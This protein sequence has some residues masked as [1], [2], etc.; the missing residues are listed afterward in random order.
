MHFLLPLSRQLRS[1]S[2]YERERGTFVLMNRDYELYLTSE[3]WS[4]LREQALNRA[5]RKCE[6]CRSIKS[7]QGHHLLYRPALT[8]CTTDDIMSL[9]DRCHKLWHDWL[10][11]TGRKLTEFCRQSTRGALAVLLNA[12]KKAT[13]AKTACVDVPPRIS[14]KEVRKIKANTKVE[15]RKIREEKRAALLSV[16]EFAEALKMDRDKFKKYIRASAP[17]TKERA[18]YFSISMAL[19]DKI[20][21]SGMQAVQQKTEQPGKFSAAHRRALWEEAKRKHGTPPSK[22]CSSYYKLG[23]N[24]TQPNIRY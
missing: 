1:E 5:N 24:D 10:K 15:K 23:S 13:T 3:H 17:Q 14:T 20:Q 8:D 6:A 18:S 7:L 11:E 4:Q 2:V 16:P 22:I 12:P 21:R 9:C 19:Y